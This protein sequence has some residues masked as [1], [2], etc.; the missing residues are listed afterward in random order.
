[1]S[2]QQHPTKN[3]S[4]KLATEAKTF[5]YDSAFDVNYG[6][7][8][9]D[10]QEKIRKA[11]VTIVG[12]GGLGGPVAIILARSGITNFVLIDNDVFD[13]SNINRQIGAFVDTLGKYKAQVTKEEILRINPEADVEAYTRKLSFDELGELIDRSDVFIPTADDF[14]YSSIATIMAQERKKFTIG[15]VPCGMTGYC[16]VFPPDLT[17]I[18]DPMD[19]IGGSKNLS[20]EELHQFIDDPQNRAA[21]RWYITEGRYRIEWFNKWLVK[22]ARLAQLCPNVWL[23]ASLACI[24]V[25]K[26][27]TGKWQTTRVPKM[28]HPLTAENRIKV[29][30]FRIRTRLFN[31]IVYW[32]FNIKW[33]GIGERIRNF[34]SKQLQEELAE[35]ERQEKEGKKVKLPFLWRHII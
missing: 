32:A 10:E 22:E 13:I 8:S 34:T 16:W 5:D 18:I 14:A 2:N 35:M 21:R 23:V 19:L 4:A 6:I 3:T 15:F 28:W 1:M 33:L 20:Y 26:Y 27:L 17:R 9:K 7:F 30:R 31:K 24:E 25:L 12:T 29:E 11:R